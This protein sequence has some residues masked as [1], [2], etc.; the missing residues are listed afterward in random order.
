SAATT[1]AALL[2]RAM[3]RGRR[4]NIALNT[5]RAAS[6]FVPSVSVMSSPRK[7]LLSPVR[8]IYVDMGSP[9]SGV[10]APLAIRLIVRGEADEARHPSTQPHA[11]SG[12]IGRRQRASDFIVFEGLTRGVA[13]ALRAHLDAP[14]IK[15]LLSCRYVLHAA[16]GLRWGFMSE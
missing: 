2:T 13:K 5:A 16:I 3:R 9:R 15:E 8:S 14:L 4:S 6:Y 1:S 10:P 11:S 7:R 12:A